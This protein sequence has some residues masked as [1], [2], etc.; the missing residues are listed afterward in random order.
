MRVSDSLFDHVADV[1]ELFLGRH[2]PAELIFFGIFDVVKVKLLSLNNNGIISVSG[3]QIQLLH[4]RNRLL[5]LQ[6]IEVLHHF[7][8]SRYSLD[9]MLVILNLFHFLI[10]ELPHMSLL[11]IGANQI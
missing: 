1:L 5:P 8:K 6:L 2:V 10:E 4:E 7:F 3:H 9:P 11:H